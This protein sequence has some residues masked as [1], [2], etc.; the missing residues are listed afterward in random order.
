MM[1]AWSRHKTD[2]PKFLQGLQLS[3]PEVKCQSSHWWATEI[4]YAG[5]MTPWGN[6]LVIIDFES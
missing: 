4:Y 1:I 3:H 6:F 5:D 2:L